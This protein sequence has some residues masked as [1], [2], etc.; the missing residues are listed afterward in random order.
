MSRNSRKGFGF[1]LGSGSSNAELPMIEL[2]AIVDKTFVG[3]NLKNVDSVQL[4][5]VSVKAPVTVSNGREI[6]IFKP[7]NLSNHQTSSLSITQGSP[8]SV[9][10]TTNSISYVLH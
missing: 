7:L 8:Q 6:F 4:L 10:T 1:A 2:P 9:P 3:L 5:D